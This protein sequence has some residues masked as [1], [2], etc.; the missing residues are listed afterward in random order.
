[1]PLKH[2]VFTVMMPDYDLDGAVELLARLGYQ[3]VEWRVHNTA[4]RSSGPT[5]YWRSNKATVDVETILDKAKD[6][7]QMTDD[8]GLETI[9]LGTY[10]NYMMLDEVERCMAAARIMGAQSIRVGAPQYDGSET[11]RPS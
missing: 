2:A 10:L 5:D 7:R 6:I 4:T 1:M 8:A 3:G 9:A 11:Q